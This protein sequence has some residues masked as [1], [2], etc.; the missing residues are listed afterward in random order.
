MFKHTVIIFSIFSRRLIPSWAVS[1]DRF[2]PVH[3]LE[4]D[5]NSVCGGAL[6]LEIMSVDL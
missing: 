4:C 1:A 3:G 2:S 6:K 5:D